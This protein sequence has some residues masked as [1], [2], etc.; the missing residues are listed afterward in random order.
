M[1]NLTTHI[2]YFLIVCVQNEYFILCQVQFNQVLY[3]CMLVHTK[4]RPNSVRAH[5]RGQ[6][7][8][9]LEIAIDHTIDVG[10]LTQQHHVLLLTSLAMTRFGPR[11][12]PITSPTPGKCATSYATDT[13]SA[14]LCHFA[15]MGI[16]Y[17]STRKLSLQ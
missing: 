6:T 13:G 17:S 4:F 1:S 7:Q 14:G 16:I 8:R 10:H 9:K 15:W 12:E 2:F 3:P 5:R 11:I